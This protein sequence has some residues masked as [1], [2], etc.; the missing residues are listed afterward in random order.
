ML[1]LNREMRGMPLSTGDWLIVVGGFTG[2]LALSVAT[3]LGG[4]RFGLDGLEGM[5]R[6]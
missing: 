3:W 4:M 6:G 1:Y 5:N 2:A